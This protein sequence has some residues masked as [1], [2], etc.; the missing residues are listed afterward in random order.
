MSGFIWLAFLNVM[1][2]Y[3]AHEVFSIVTDTSM[4]GIGGGVLC[5]LREVLQCPVSFFSR[6][7]Q[8]RETKYSATELECL[9]VVDTL[10]H[11]E[12]HLVDR[13]FTIYTDHKALPHQF[14][15]LYSSQRKAWALYVMDF[16]C[17]IQ[18]RPGKLNTVADF[19]SRQAWS[20]SDEQHIYCDKDP[21]QFGARQPS[22]SVRISSS[23]L[24]S[25][26]RG[27]DVGETHRL[28][29]VPHKL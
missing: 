8:D 19:L 25:K 9:A 18:Y 27:G 24:S 11:F 5:V 12:V 23:T 16:N 10:K 14:T 3:S 20:M 1:I 2:F 4:Y 7:L 15:Q 28:Q 6:Q 17:S 21:Q 13:Q 26:G 22:S 29:F